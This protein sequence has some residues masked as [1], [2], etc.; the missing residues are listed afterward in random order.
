MPEVC[1]QYINFIFFRR[2]KDLSGDPITVNKPNHGVYAISI[3]TTTQITVSNNTGFYP[4]VPVGD[5]P[6]ELDKRYKPIQ[7]TGS[8][9]VTEE[10]NEIK[11]EP[12]SEPADPPL[13]PPPDDMSGV[14]VVNSSEIT[15]IGEAFD[16]GVGIVNSTGIVIQGS[17]IGVDASGNALGNSG[18]GI[19][20]D[21]TSGNITIGGGVPGAGNTI[22][23]NGG[24][25]IDVAGTNVAIS[26]NT[27]DGTN[28]TGV[29]VTGGTSSIS[30][31]TTLVN[32]SVSGG[33][34]TV[35]GSSAV[36]YLTVAGGTLI[37]SAPLTVTGQ[38]VQSG[39]TLVVTANQAFSAAQATINPGSLI[40]LEG[41]TLAFN[42]GLQLLYGASLVGAGTVQG[43]LVNAGTVN[44]GESPF[45]RGTLLVTGNYTQTSSGT[46]NVYLD[47]LSI[48]ALDHLM[49]NGLASLGG[50]FNANLVG[51]YIPPAGTTFSVLEWSS[52][53]GSLFSSIN[54]PFYQGG[55][56]SY[57]YNLPPNAF[58]LFSSGT[59]SG[60]APPP[61]P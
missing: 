55:A 54:L 14:Q 33:A 11:V 34:L 42:N 53:D 36:Q 40:D 27:I 10:G 44:I 20:I 2:S 30:G 49:V 8:T 28:G 38:Y 4:R 47:S 19:F 17:Y 57:A 18:D 23:D 39:G 32:V 35:S 61:P 52:W 1:G 6:I 59:L 37:D 3:D 7:I 16:Q 41:G 56:F 43:N 31:T 9:K 58:S 12:A 13:P 51:G 22:A 29:V 5:S 21:P 24:A 46:L 60:G 15:M 25:G 45:A 50:T 48:A 26:G